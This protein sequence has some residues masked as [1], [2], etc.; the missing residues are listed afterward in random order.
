MGA[1]LK[2]KSGGAKGSKV[3]KG[4]TKSYKPKTKSY[5]Q[6]SK[7]GGGD[8]EITA[9]AF[10]VQRPDAESRARVLAGQKAAETDQKKKKKK[11]YS[12]DHKGRMLGAGSRTASAISDG[13][14][15]PSA[16][17]MRERRLRFLNMQQQTH[18]QSAQEEKVHRVHL[19]LTKN[20]DDLQGRKKPKEGEQADGEDE[21]QDENEDEEFKREEDEDDGDDEEDDDYEDGEDVKEASG[22][23][24][25]ET[26]EAEAKEEEETKE[27]KA[28]EKADGDG[29]KWQDE[30]DDDDG[31]EDWGDFVRQETAEHLI[32]LQNEIVL[33]CDLNG[34][35]DEV[36]AAAYAAA[37]STLL[38]VAQNAK[39]PERRQLRHVNQ[40]F[41]QAVGRWAGGAGLMHLLGFTLSQTMKAGS[42]SELEM[43]WVVGGTH[44]LTCTHNLY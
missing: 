31:D 5:K 39:R 2:A 36:A 7:N 20:D 35:L 14:E 17:E 11:Q 33:S 28:E 1:P 38:K 21:A 34:Q 19:G 12:V 25:D 13:L 15:K 10:H 8:T 37:V 29:I 6:K 9:P 18:R 23:K 26:K 42:S 27:E 3:S 40:R 32:E 41:Q 24:E 4:K 44:A 22:A 43:I 16:E 30:D